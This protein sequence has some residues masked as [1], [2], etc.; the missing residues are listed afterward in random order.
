[1]SKTCVS[2]FGLFVAGPR[3]LVFCF[4][5]NDQF[6]DLRGEREDEGGLLDGR[7]A[8][9]GSVLLTHDVCRVFC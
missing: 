5:G 4:F 8:R 6:D 3:D 7:G 1:M 9:F 2:L